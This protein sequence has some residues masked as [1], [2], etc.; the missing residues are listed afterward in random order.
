MRPTVTGTPFI[1]SD[2]LV[3]VPFGEEH[4]TSR[5]VAWLNDPEVVRWSEQRH[6]VHTLTSCR[7][8][9]ESFRG[10]PNHFW[11]IEADG[12]G[13]IGNLNAYVRGATADLGILVGERD[14]WGQGYG[15]EAWNA[16]CAYLLGEGGCEAVTAGTRLDND[17][18]RCVMRR[19]GMAEERT[20]RGFVYA[21]K[22]RDH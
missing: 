12:L 4:L 15:S 13:H 5:Y 7:A 11:A 8:Y 18:M 2:R 14:A 3:L 20:D 19:A 17:A 1:E 10:T 22:R 9:W 6:V 16:A 21:R